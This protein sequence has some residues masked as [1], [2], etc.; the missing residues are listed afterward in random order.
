MAITKLQALNGFARQPL[1]LVDASAREMALAAA[2][3]LLVMA[4]T[5]A[6]PATD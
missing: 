1:R 3:V 6:I 5:S 2:I 4:G